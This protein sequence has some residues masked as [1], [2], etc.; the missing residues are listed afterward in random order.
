MKKTLIASAAVLLAAAAMAQNKVNLT[1]SNGQVESYNTAAVSSIGLDGAR[2]TVNPVDGAARVYDSNVRNISFIKNTAGHVELIEAGGWL[3]TAYVKWNNFAGA[4]NYEVYVKGGAL[5]DWTRLDY[6]LVRNYGTYGRADMPGLAAGA[7]SLRVVPVVDGTPVVEAASE[8]GPLEVR[9]HDRSGFAHMNYPDGVGAY[10]ND[11]TLK[12]GAKVLYIT[13]GN[14]KTVSTLVID[15]NKGGTVRTG[16]QDIIDAYQKGLDKTPIAFRIIGR[17][18]AADMDALSSSAEGLQI[19]GK[20]ADSELNITIEGIG[21]D[22]CF[23][24]MGMLVRNS[25]SVEIRNIG[26]FYC[27]DDAISLDTDNSNIWI[28][29]NDIFYGNNKGGDQAK[30]DGSIDVKSDS[31]Y[32]TVSYNHFVDTGKSSLCGMKSESGPNWITYHHNWFDH[33]DSRHPRIR[34]MSVHVWNNYYDGISKYGVGATTGSDAFVEA[35]YF[36]DCK[37]PILTSLQGSDVMGEGSSADGK[38]TFSGE[39]GGSIKAFGNVMRGWYFYRPWSE[40]NATEFDCWEAPSRDARMPGTIK[41]KSGGDTYTN[42]D[43][44][45]AL[46]YAYT[47]DRAEDV[48]AI[49]TGL[50][51]AG[52]INHG[53]FRWTFDNAT[54][55]KNS[56]VIP[57]LS[58]AVSNYRNTLTG[59]YEGTTDFGDKAASTVSG[60]DASTGVEFPFGDGNFAPGFGGGV[61]PPPGPSGNGEA[62]IASEDGSDYLWFNAANQAKVEALIADGTIV[63]TDGESASSFRPDTDPSNASVTS[64]KGAGVIQLG[65]NGGGMIVKCPSIS[66]FKVSMFR[67]GSYKGSIEKSTDNGATWTSLATL[68]QKKGNVELDLSTNAA[69]D[70]E[71]LVRITNTSTGGLNIHGLLILKSA[72]K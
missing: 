28:H 60:G 41:A 30:G 29:N 52:R 49:V 31:K 59:F 53:D 11:G 51:G 35:N 3:E 50:Y 39:T 4:G 61:T 27:I 33:S 67:T 38:G 69:S 55:D 70:G 21:D 5:A 8:T 22:A 34:T 18:D 12:D 9:A 17:I 62:F 15:N 20:N 64:S 16:F 68:S 42:W 54:Q 25:R 65:K 6:Q 48:P 24:H 32:V 36:R 71:T 37:Y 23:H 7:Y 44:D 66:V 46:M 57:A 26:V 13:A 10:K 1:L 47:P 2:V 63:L 56:E 40:T 19:K 14:A 45:P 43:T 58:S 72:A